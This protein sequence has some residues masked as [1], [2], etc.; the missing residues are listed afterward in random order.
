MVVA[1]KCRLPEAVLVKVVGLWAEK[2]SF[3]DTDDFV[4]NLEIEVEKYWSLEGIANQLYEMGV[5]LYRKVST[6]A[7]WVFFYFLI[8]I[9]IEQVLIQIV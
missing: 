9:R 8:L 3:D 2:L 6:S 5:H 7:N 4:A 1:A